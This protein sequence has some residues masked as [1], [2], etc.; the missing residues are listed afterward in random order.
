[1][2]D[3][4]SVVAVGTIIVM[5]V[6]SVILYVLIGLFIK[7]GMGWARIVGAVLAVV[8]LSQLIALTMPGGI[9]TILQV[10][11][12]LAAMVLCFT[13]PAAAYFKERKNFKLA[14]K[15]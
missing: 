8:S 9:A 7:R 15:A 14:Q 3:T 10:L 11:L 12:G 13:G 1:M 6:V 4:I 2:I 5:A